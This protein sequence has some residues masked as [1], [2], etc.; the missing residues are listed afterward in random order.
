VVKALRQLPGLIG[1]KK[2]GAEEIA[3]DLVTGSWRRLVFADPVRKLGPVDKA[4]Y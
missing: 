3:R 1:R 4:A 2:I